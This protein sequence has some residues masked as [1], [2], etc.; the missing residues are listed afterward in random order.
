MPRALRQW[1]PGLLLL[2]PSLILLAVFVYGLIG[3]TDQPVPAGQAQRPAVQGIRRPRATTRTCSPTTSATGS[4]HSLKNLR[5]LHGRVHRRHARSW[6]C[7]GR[8]CWNAGARAEGF[9]RTD[10][11]V[12]DGGVVRRLRRGV[13]LADELRHRRQRRRPQRHLRRA[14]PRLPGE[15]VVDRPRLGHGRDGAAGDLAAVR[16]HHGAVPGRLP[17]HPARAARGRR[18]G[19]RHHLPALPARA[20]PAADPGRAVRAD[21]HRPHV[22]E[23]VRPDH[24]GVRRPVPHRGAR[25]ST[26]GRRCSPTTRPRPPRSRSS[27]CCVV[28]VVIVPY[29]IY[30]NRAEKRS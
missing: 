29:L 2:S 27:C 11:P 16:L 7:S 19:R 8:S 28:A 6:A 13:A 14:A 25:R 5:H 26:S 10:L 30:V 15:P 9:F 24:V 1:G 23:D 18:H 17:G 4:S 22:D 21:H 12:P 20:V 3:W